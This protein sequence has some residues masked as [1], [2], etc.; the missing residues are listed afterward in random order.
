[1]NYIQ[2]LLTFPRIELSANKAGLEK[3]LALWT[4]TF[5]PWFFFCWI[6]SASAAQISSKS[7]KPPHQQGLSTQRARLAHAWCVAH[8]GQR[9]IS[10]AQ[11]PEQGLKGCQPWCPYRHSFALP[12]CSAA[13][14]RFG[15]QRESLCMRSPILAAAFPPTSADWGIPWSTAPLVRLPPLRPHSP[16]SSGV[17]WGAGWG[18]SFLC[19]ARRRCTGSCRCRPSSTAGSGWS[20][21]WRTP[22]FR[23]G[24]PAAL[25]GRSRGERRWGTAAGDMEPHGA[26]PRARRAGIRAPG[27]GRASER[28]RSALGSA[29]PRQWSRPCGDFLSFF[30]FCFNYPFFKSS[31]MAA[32][33]LPA[34]AKPLL[35]K[36]ERSRSSPGQGGGHRSNGAATPGSPA[37]TSGFDPSEIGL[38]RRGVR[39]KGWNPR[40]GAQRVE[41]GCVW[42]CR[43]AGEVGA[44]QNSPLP[45]P[46]LGTRRG[47]FPKDSPGVEA[48]Q[49]VY[50]PTLILNAR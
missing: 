5:Q 26:L 40:R 23:T 29:I 30:F 45:K 15:S 48:G 47:G 20:H 18:R 44:C 32:D 37:L 19:R 10:P 35:Y 34:P 16:L 22:G 21:S 50:T 6:H 49:G 46:T 28:G 9:S 43:G 13:L 4:N 42:L 24:L 1:M 14:L 36:P 8:R 39:G 38:K 12:I 25:G 7:P 2:N 17:W 27:P 3:F 31:L 11:G 33:S 41:K